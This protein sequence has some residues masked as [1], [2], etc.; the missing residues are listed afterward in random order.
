[1]ALESPNITIHCFHLKLPGISIFS[2]SGL[3]L[4]LGH[5]I[6]NQLREQLRKSRCQLQPC[7]VPRRTNHICHLKMIKIFYFRKLGDIGN[8]LLKSPQ[9]PTK[10]RRTNTNIN[11]RNLDHDRNHVSFQFQGKIAKVISTGLEGMFCF[12]YCDVNR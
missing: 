5:P 7:S 6:R 9:P 1:M 2:S 10:I 11:N 3:E 8:F 12:V 4:Q